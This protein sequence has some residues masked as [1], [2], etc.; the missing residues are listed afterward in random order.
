MFM[1]D[2]MV[3]SMPS[4]EMAE[5]DAGA[6]DF[7]GTNNQVDGVDEADSV[8]ND[9]QYI[10]MLPK[11]HGVSQVCRFLRAHLL[12][13]LC[14]ADKVCLWQ[15]LVIARAYPAETAEVI[16]TTDLMV[17]GLWPTSLL[18]FDDVRFLSHP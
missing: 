16:S 3:P 4:P 11:A 7:S 14:V 13:T 8:K 2:D 10:Y 6:E 15:T 18:L 9:G 5:Q 17:Y 1:Y 12:E